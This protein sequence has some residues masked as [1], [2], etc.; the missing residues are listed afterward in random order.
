MFDFIEIM[1]CTVE[2]KHRLKNCNE[3]PNA[4]AYQLINNLQLWEVS[5]GT[6]SAVTII[7]AYVKLFHFLRWIMAM[8]EF[9]QQ[10]DSCFL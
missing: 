10:S 8:A 6:T 7:L 5:G 3:V 4:P 9:P 1:F 2:T